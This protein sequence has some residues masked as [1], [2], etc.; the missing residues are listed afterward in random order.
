MGN[1]ISVVDMK[2]KSYKNILC[3]S[4]TETRACVWNVPMDVFF[5]V[6]YLFDDIKRDY[7]Y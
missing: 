2:L 3:N 1:E 6:Y 7:W 5:E 4:I